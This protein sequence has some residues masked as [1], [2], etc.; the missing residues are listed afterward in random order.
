MAERFGCKPSTAKKE[1]KRSISTGHARYGATW[2]SHP[3]LSPRSSASNAEA[4]LL[5]NNLITSHLTTSPLTH[6]LF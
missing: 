6:G 4:P 3:S 2:S 5:P 1:I